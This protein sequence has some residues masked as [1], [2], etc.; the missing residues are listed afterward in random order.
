MSNIVKDFHSKTVMNTFLKYVVK[1]FMPPDK[2]QEWA[3]EYS[4]TTVN[5]FEGEEEIPEFCKKLDKHLS[6]V[7]KDLANVEVSTYHTDV[8]FSKEL[9]LISLSLSPKYFY[10][11]PEIDKKTGHTRVDVILNLVEAANQYG[12][13]MPLPEYRGK[14]YIHESGLNKEFL[15]EYFPD[16]GFSIF[17]FVWTLMNVPELQRSAEFIIGTWHRIDNNPEDIKDEL[18]SKVSNE[19]LDDEQFISDCL[20]SGM[21]NYGHPLEYASKRIQKLYE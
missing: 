11:F 9:Q 4:N 14:D 10:T 6:E 16:D 7:H 3:T 8:R 21:N 2:F 20:K 17:K 12:V 19:L 18:F 15:L 13:S 1:E 5:L